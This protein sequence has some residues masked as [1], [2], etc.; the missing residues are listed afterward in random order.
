MKQNIFKGWSLEINHK[1]KES[2]SHFNVRFFLY[3]AMNA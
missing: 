3:T 1:E 2:F